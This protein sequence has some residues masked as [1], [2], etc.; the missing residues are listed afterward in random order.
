MK[1]SLKIKRKLQYFL[2]GDHDW[3][4]M[5]CYIDMFSHS[6]P[7]GNFKELMKNA[8]INERGEKEIPF[9]DYVITKAEYDEI[10]EFYK[11][12]LIYDHQKRKLAYQIELGCSPRYD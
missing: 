4:M 11:T 2:A 3:I 5:H 10:L 7:E 12:F 1:K 6:T 9:D 8:T